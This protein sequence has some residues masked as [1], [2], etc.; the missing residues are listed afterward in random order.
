MKYKNENVF[1]VVQ[2]SHFKENDSRYYSSPESLKMGAIQQYSAAFY[3]CFDDDLDQEQESVTSAD[4]PVDRNSHLGNDNHSAVHS[5][6]ISCSPSSGHL[7]SPS[8]GGPVSSSINQLSNSIHLRSPIRL[9]VNNP[10]INSTSPMVTSSGCFAN[11]IP[12]PG[13]LE[14][15]SSGSFDTDSL[16]RLRNL[17][18]R[19]RVRNVN[20]GFDRLRKHLPN[21]LEFKKDKRLSKVQTLKMAITYIRQLESILQNSSKPLS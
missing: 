4:S 17:R 9:P 21:Q 15:I 2:E 16:I 11:R 6:T 12:L 14:A 10:F 5:T 8:S 13:E 20:D 7:P 1:N 3:Y 19:N 18:E